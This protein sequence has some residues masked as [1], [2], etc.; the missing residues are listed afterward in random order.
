M[1]VDRAEQEAVL[2]KFMIAVTS[3]DL[4]GLLELLAPDVV[5]I[6]DGGGLVAAARKPLSGAQRVAA[7]IARLAELPE[8]V[9]TT[10]WFNGRPGVR[11]DVGSD[12]SVVSLVVED[13]RITRIYA[14]RNPSKLGRLGKLA[15]LR[16]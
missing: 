16:R 11:I 1:E 14:I 10:A 2:E 6:V 4:Q 13:D 15:E 8:F 9:S 7:F 3:G 5:L 12:V